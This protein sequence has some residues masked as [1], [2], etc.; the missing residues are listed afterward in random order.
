MFTCPTY[1]I[2]VRQDRI[3]SA[4]KWEN[5]RVANRGSNIQC[6]ILAVG[7]VKTLITGLA[8]IVQTYI[9]NHDMGNHGSNGILAKRGPVRNV[10]EVI[11]LQL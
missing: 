10:W 4:A 5:V 2:D 1:T 9:L 6:L 8:F 3:P 7:Q 11:R